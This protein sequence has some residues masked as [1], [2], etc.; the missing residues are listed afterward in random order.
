[1]LMRLV[2]FSMVLLSLWVFES[3]AAEQGILRSQ[4]TLYA[5]SSS[6]ADKLRS[7][8]SASEVQILKRSGGW[9]NVRL[10][11]GTTGWL[12]LSRVKRSG[13]AVSAAA[14]TR[15]TDSADIDQLMDD[16]LLSG[17]LGSNEVTTA[18]GIRGLDKDNI[19]NATP[20]ERAVDQLDSQTVKDTEAIDFAEKGGL[21]SRKIDYLDV[22][23]PPES[24]RSS[25]GNSSAD[26]GFGE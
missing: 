15:K 3:S 24:S 21:K 14:G 8:D 26:F 1:M 17:R 25:G 18:T 9:Y 23:K 12:R 13:A 10:E 22:K 6:N 20:D 19:E 11:D 7:L 4:A 16:A 2:A 5:E